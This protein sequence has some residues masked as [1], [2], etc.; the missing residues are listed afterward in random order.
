MKFGL[1][2]DFANPDRWRRP[3]PEFYRAILDQVI[4]A[5]DL[6][7]DN[8]WLSEHHFVENGYNPSLLPTAA[9]IASRTTR[10]RIG[11]CVVLLPFHNPVRVAEDATCVDIWSGGRFD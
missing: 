10:I 8:V 9:A 5:E 2:E 7:Y 1:I 4:K 6:A 3:W 11:T